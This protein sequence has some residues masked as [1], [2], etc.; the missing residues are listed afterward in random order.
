MGNFSVNHYTRIEVAPSQAEITYVLDLAEI[1]AFEMLR[2]WRLVATSPQS[3]LQAK[4]AEQARI[5]L[6]GLDFHAGRNSVALQPKFVAASIQLTDGAGGLSTARITST[7]RLDGLRG[8][9]EFEDHNF[10][11]R[12]GWKEIVI[13][14]SNGAGIARASQGDADRGQALESYPAD[15][16]AAPPQDLRASVEWRTV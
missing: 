1:P 7:M 16:T 10:P 11:D 12:A 2:D 13:R 3:E 4:A 15:P 9:L 5:W 14:S 8:S 6:R